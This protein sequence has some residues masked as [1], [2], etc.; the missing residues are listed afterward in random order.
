MTDYKSKIKDIRNV[1]PV[2]MNEALELL[3]KYNGDVGRCIDEAKRNN[4]NFIC[5]Q[6]GCTE[7][8]AAKVYEDEKYD[9]NRAVSSMREIIYDRHYKPIEG[10]T[11]E[12]IR[13]VLDW[14]HIV[15]AKDFITALEYQRLTAVINTLQCIDSLREMS[16][17]LHEAKRIR[18]ILLADA[19]N[20]TNEEFI[21]Q[22]TILDVDPTVAKGVATFK[23]KET[24]MK[25]E[26][27][28]HLRNLQ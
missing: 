9:L 23:L 24:V 22:N 1:I 14:M 3:T 5:R 15:T 8:E 6:T 18:D 25:E 11:K 27:L 7:S 26:L 2:P 20:M 13:A 16:V 4:I 28:R 19:D 12:S 10:V 17:V 21:R